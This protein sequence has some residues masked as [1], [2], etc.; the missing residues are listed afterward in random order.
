MLNETVVR[1]SQV[2]NIVA[3]KD[4]TGDVERGAKALIRGGAG[5]FCRVLGR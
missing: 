2:D 4:A 5:R 1:L 3:I